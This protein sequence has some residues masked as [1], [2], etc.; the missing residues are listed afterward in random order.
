[1]GPTRADP[2]SHTITLRDSHPTSQKR[3]L[4]DTIA[5]ALALELA[6]RFLVLARLFQRDELGLGEHR[7]SLG[8]PGLQRFQA[9]SHRFQIV[10]LPDAAHAS[11]RHAQAALLQLIGHPQLAER[12]LLQRQ[13]HHRLLNARIDAV[14]QARLAAGHLLQ[15]DLA[16]FFV[17]LFE[18]VEAVA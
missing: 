16:T 1:L 4:R 13:G 14:L 5:G 8:H 6:A 15:G 11:R 10:A 18:P 3:I 17:Q 9:L 2:A 12:G 7:A